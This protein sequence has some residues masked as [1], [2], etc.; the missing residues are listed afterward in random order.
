M[1]TFFPFDQPDFWHSSYGIT[2][3][4]L[5]F[6]CTTVIMLSFHAKMGRKLTVILVVACG[7]CFAMI[8][9]NLRILYTTEPAAIIQTK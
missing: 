6:V 8:C 3:L 9:F 2:T 7:L 1:S 5:L 4:I